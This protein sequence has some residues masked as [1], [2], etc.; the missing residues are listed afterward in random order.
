MA[1]KERFKA[2]V[3]KDPSR[4]W[5]HT[6]AI[7]ARDYYATKINKLEVGKTVYVQ[8]DDL[9][10]SRTNAQNNLYWMY[11]SNIAKETG[12]DDVTDQEL[13]ELFKSDYL[14][15][16]RKK[17][18]GKEIVITKST[19]ELSKSEFALYLMK[20]EKRTGIPI[21]D[22][23]GY[24]YGT[25]EEQEARKQLLDSQYPEAEDNEVKF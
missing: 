13:H 17:V 16:G 10:T 2:K 11:L 4:P 18:L 25:K 23:E 12:G 1:F 21:P 15:L 3:V 7:E 22:T 9:K 19:A 5:R 6:I 24:V 14:V 8:I 20:I